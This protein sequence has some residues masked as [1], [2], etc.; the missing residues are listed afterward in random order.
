MSRQNR[1]GLEVHDERSNPMAGTVTSPARRRAGLRALAGAAALLLAAS[2]AAH[3][4]DLPVDAQA[5]AWLESLPDARRG[6]ATF[7]FEDPERFRFRW[8]PGRREG[9]RLDELGVSDTAG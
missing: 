3:S 7:V 9:V 2:C 8:T 4:S 1:Q 6:R 5:R